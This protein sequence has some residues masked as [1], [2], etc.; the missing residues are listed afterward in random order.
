MQL[1]KGFG[2]SWQLWAMLSLPL[3]YLMIFRYYPMYGAQIAFRDYIGTAG[4][5]GS[6]WVGLKHF[7]AF[8]NSYY[9]F[10]LLRNTI[11]I[12]LYQLV[13]G[14]PVPVILALALNQIRA[15]GYKKVIQMVTYM[16]HFISTVVLVS[17]IHLFLNPRLGVI[18]QVASVF[19]MEIGNVLG[20]PKYF[21]TIYVVSGVWQRMGYQSIIYIAALSSIDPQLH[22]AAIIDGAGRV[23]RIRHIDFPGILP[24]VVVLLVLQ[25]GHIMRVGFEKIYLMQNPMNIPVSEIIET[26]VYKVGLLQASFSYA[27]A[28]GLFNNVINLF[29]LIT[30]NRIAR[31]MTENSL[32]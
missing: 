25:V 12:S 19:G 10:R 15:R 17:L 30:V 23:Q 18:A 31:R 14:F 27:S 6:R 8:F 20:E 28:V 2:K 22:E 21:R 7:N 16:P 1:Q 3:L 13:L 5:W 11:S 26:H 32:W 4:F 9:F 29:L 24:T